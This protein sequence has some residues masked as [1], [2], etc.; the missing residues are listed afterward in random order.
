ML[1]IAQPPRTRPASSTAAAGLAIALSVIVLAVQPISISAQTEQPYRICAGDVLRV[2][3]FA[4]EEASGE[5]RVGPGGT[6]TM[7]LLGQISLAG[8]TIE[9][10]TEDVR[11][12]LGELVRQPYV[13][14]GIEE[15]KSTREVS[16]YGYVE[17]Q[18][19]IILPFG[20]HL[21]HA[22]AAAGTTDLSDLRRVRLTRGGEAPQ[23]VDLSGIRTAEPIENNPLLASGDEVYVPKVE[24]EVVLLGEVEA[25]ATFSIP[26]G[27]DLTLL[28]LL[29]KVGQALTAKADRSQAIMLKPGQPATF[30]DLHALLI[31]GDLS[32]DIRLTGGEVIVIKEARK[33]SVVGE[34]NTPTTFHTSRP[35]TVLE[36]LA[37]A[38]GFTENADLRAAQIVS[39]DGTSRSVDI[40]A[41]WTTGALPVDVEIR[42]GDVLMLPEAEPEHVLVLGAVEKPAVLDIRKQKHPHLLAALTLA[43]PTPAGNLERVSVYRGDQCMVVDARGIIEQGILADNIELQADDVVYVPEIDAVYVL[44]G[45]QTPGKVYLRPDMV[46]LDALVAAGGT[47]PRAHLAGVVVS[48]ARPDGIAEHVRVDMSVI[49]RGGVPEPF[50]LKGGDIIYVPYTAK[51]GKTIWTLLRENLWLVSTIISLTR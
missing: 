33:V 39:A 32:K 40:E 14:L 44:G 46:L 16:V 37:A 1:R 41:L 42:P 24:E 35:I 23:I 31:E 20:A 29:G 3:I 47:V 34:V 15:T 5:Y 26:V 27:A 13:V 19:S 49:K 12:R 7:P 17:Q 51:P 43:A 38:G 21:T 10:A 18:G 36:A 2:E 6:I 50:Q 9:Q 48:R 25:P 45:V 30:I 22:L 4:L 11:E 8:M 28:K